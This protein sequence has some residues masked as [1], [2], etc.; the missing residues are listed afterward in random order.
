[1][2]HIGDL[3]NGKKSEQ[4][5]RNQKCNT[6][7]GCNFQLGGLVDFLEKMIFE[8]YVEDGEVGCH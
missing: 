4:S 6:H 1:M 2:W 3:C 7:G 5:K 8:E